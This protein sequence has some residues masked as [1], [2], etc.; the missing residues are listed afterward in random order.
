MT[1]KYI[2][3]FP[4]HR[5]IMWPSL[6]KIRY[7]ELKLLCAETCVDARHTQSH[8][9]APSWDRHIKINLIK[10][11]WRYQRGN[12]NPYIEEE[13]TTQWPKEKVQKDKQRSTKHTHKTKD[14]V[15]RTPLKTGGELINID[16]VIVNR[17]RLY[18]NR[19]TVQSQTITG[20]C[21]THGNWMDTMMT[22]AYLMWTPISHVNLIYKVF[23]SDWKTG[24]LRKVCNNM[25]TNIFCTISLYQIG[26]EILTF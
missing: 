1:P 2:G 16:R 26:C 10:R 8:N 14:R 13:Q 4:F 7:T 20:N 3:F 25:Y 19:L 11:V 24:H 17:V 18:N 22:N 5:G 21:C 23:V 15:T 9:T 6:I 12:Q